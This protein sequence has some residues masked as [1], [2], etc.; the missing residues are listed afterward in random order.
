MLVIEDLPVNSIKNY[1]TFIIKLKTEQ[2]GTIQQHRY[3]WDM[4]FLVTASNDITPH[5]RF[6]LIRLLTL[7]ITQ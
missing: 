1:I 6:N 7:I 5:C 2:I 4:R 3:Y